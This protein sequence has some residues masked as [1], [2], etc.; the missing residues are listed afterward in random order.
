MMPCV[1]AAPDTP[2]PIKAGGSQPFCGTQ[3][4]GVP[5]STYITAVSELLERSVWILLL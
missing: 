5:V 1:E 4:V 3:D 2:L